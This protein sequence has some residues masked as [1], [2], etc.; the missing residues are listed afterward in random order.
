MDW[1]EQFSPMKIHWSKKWLSIPYQ[2]QTVVLQG[3]TSS[4]D[5]KHL[6][7]V[8]YLLHLA[9]ETSTVPQLDPRI[10]TVLQQFKS[11]FDEPTMLPP[12]RSYD[13]IIPLVLSAQPVFIRPYRYAPAVK[14]EIERQVSEMLASGIIQHSSSPFSIPVLLVRKKDQSWRFCVDFR[15]LNAL[16]VKRKYP[17]PII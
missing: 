1:L 17:M 6:L 15:H 12:S 9:G 3:N 13:H 7:H 16:T 4:M 2:G 8:V 14:D 11:V 5:N 10:A